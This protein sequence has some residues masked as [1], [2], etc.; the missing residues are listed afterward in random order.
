MKRLHLISALLLVL[1]CGS[2]LAQDWSSGQSTG[3]TAASYSQVGDLYTIVLKNMSG[4]AV[5]LNTPDYDVV[6]WSLQLFNV[7]VPQTNITMPDGWSWD[8]SKFGDAPDEKYFTPPSLAPG[9]TYTFS[10]RS[11][12]TTL[13]ND[14][15][16][17][18]GL[19]GFLAHLGTVD[20]T[21]PGSATQQWN[22]Y[23]N[24]FTWHDIA[25]LV[26]EPG[27]LFALATGLIGS[28]G[29]VLRRKH[30]AV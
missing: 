6:V 19:P 5:D 25:S 8:G 18:D 1:A 14:G 16:K 28:V 11:T 23:R 29:L 7:P 24:G 27:S 10:Y 12:S 21:P 4:T 26:P 3:L 15:S 22:A 17:S 20:P 9:Q 2:V 30:N 13:V